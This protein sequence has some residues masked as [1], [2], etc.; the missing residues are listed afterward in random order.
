MRNL[1]QKR[2]MV[3]NG[4]EPFYFKKTPEKSKEVRKRFLVELHFMWKR[5]FV[6]HNFVCV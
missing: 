1:F 5:H 2:I 6:E 3:G 4:Q